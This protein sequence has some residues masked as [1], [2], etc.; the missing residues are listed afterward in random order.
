MER[1]LLVPLLVVLLLVEVCGLASADESLPARY[2]WAK[3][4]M[5]LVH[6]PHHHA[7]CLHSCALAMLGLRLARDGSGAAAV[8]GDA[9]VHRPPL[10]PPLS[11]NAAAGAAASPPEL[12]S[13]GSVKM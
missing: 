6:H 12:P 9:A 7:V 2:C 8:G 4:A 1:R 5:Q 13:P 3:A 11:S 10:P